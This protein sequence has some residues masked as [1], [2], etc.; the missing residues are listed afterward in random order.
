MQHLV[1][2]FVGA[3]G[4]GF[5]FCRSTGSPATPS[6][7]SLCGIP[8]SPSPRGL[9]PCAPR[10]GASISSTPTTATRTSPRSSTT[11]FRMDKATFF[12]TL[13]EE[14]CDDFRLRLAMKTEGEL[15]VTRITPLDEDDVDLLVEFEGGHRPS[16]RGAQAHRG[17]TE[18]RLGL[19]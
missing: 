14:R 17:G 4:G 7:P 8:P 13:T 16:P 18:G 9:W 3:H 15:K 12:R 2:G 5:P 19:R 11:P 10:T 1:L 6:A